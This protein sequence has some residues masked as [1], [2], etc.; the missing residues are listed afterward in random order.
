MVLCE[1]A[2]TGAC[3]VISIITRHSSDGGSGGYPNLKDRCLMKQCLQTY[4]GK[5]IY[6]MIM[7]R[8]KASPTMKLSFRSNKQKFFKD[9]DSGNDTI[10]R[11]ETVWSW[12]FLSLDI[13]PATISSFVVNLTGL[14][15]TFYPSAP[16][17]ICDLELQ[18]LN[19]LVDKLHQQSSSV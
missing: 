11:S 2:L 9:E 17:S 16:I 5:R 4:T 15:L 6:L 1:A 14:I 10:S 7:E 3:T 19:I 13:R 12:Q 8:C 18:C